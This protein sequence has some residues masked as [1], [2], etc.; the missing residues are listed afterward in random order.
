MFGLGDAGIDD[1]LLARPTVS[2]WSELIASVLRERDAQVVFRT[3]GSTGAAREVAHRFADLTDEAAHFAEIVDPDGTFHVTVPTH[4]IYGFIFGALVPSLAGQPIAEARG[5]A[6]ARVRPAPGDVIVAFPH[7]LS[8]LDRNGALVAEGLSVVSSTAP[9]PPELA[10]SVRASGV[11]LIE[12]YGS[13]ETA[14]VGFRETSGP[15]RLLPIWQRA[16]NGIRR[17]GDIPR[18]NDDNIAATPDTARVS[19]SMEIDLPDAVALPDNVEWMDDRH[20]LPIRRT[21]SAVQVGG[22]NVIPSEV[23]GVLTAHPSVT[24]A[25]VRLMQPSEGVRLKAFIVPSG[26]EYSEAELRAHVTH[27]LPSAA[28]PA[29]YTVGAA[30]PRNDMGKLCDWPV[31]SSAS[32]L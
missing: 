18:R 8:I 21:D 16:G 24:A 22:V 7:A 23:E 29:V 3:S 9:C 28:R 12:V 13:T 17:R 1:Y 14:G 26:P 27:H 15:Y 5:L 31:T 25:S 32:S 6:L 30:L 4:H 19:D 10:Q 11:R 20:F 2:D